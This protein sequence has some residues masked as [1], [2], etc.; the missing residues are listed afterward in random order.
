MGLNPQEN[1]Q[2]P[3]WR[4]GDLIEYMLGRPIYF[5]VLGFSHWQAD[6]YQVYTVWYLNFQSNNN[7][8]GYN[9]LLTE[10]KILSRI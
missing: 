8:F 1:K 6:V 5:I 10:A 9:P 4:Q 7:Y 3:E 2:E